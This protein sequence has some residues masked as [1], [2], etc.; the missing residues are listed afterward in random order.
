MVSQVFTNAISSL[1]E[2]DRQLSQIQQLLPLLRRGIGVHHGGLLPIMK[3]TIEVLFQEGLLK[4]LFATETFSI[5]LNMP[6]KTV[7]FTS[8]RKFDGKSMRWVSSGEYIQMSGRA[9]RR[10]LDERGVVIMMIDEKMEPAVA[11]D[12]VKGESDRMNSAFHLSYNMILNLLRVEGVSPEYMLE[13]CFFTFQNDANIPQYEKEMTQLEE[14]RDN[15]VVEREEEIAG[16]YEIRKQIDTYTQDVRDVM[17]HPTYALP[18]LQPG[19]LARIKYDN[20]DFGWGV[21]VTYSKASSKGKKDP[22]AEPEYIMDVLLYCSNDSSASK[23]AT[24]HTVGIKPAPS[25]NEGQ[26]MI[27]PVSLKA[28]ECMSHIRLNLP[29]NLR[30]KDSLKA[31]YKSI[32]EVKKRFPDNIPLLDPIKNMGIKDPAFQKLVSKIVVLE[33]T[34]L[35]HPL[36]QSEDLPSLY[37]KYTSK[38]E[39]IDKIKALKRRITDAQSI[40]QLEELKNRKRVMR[41]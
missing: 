9:G 19:R 35:A 36:A 16:Y 34:L 25:D 8:V 15:I 22:D 40:V 5:G 37:D 3:E 20:M 30:S 23:D 27:I 6:A 29:K 26:L 32:V 28:I 1:S 18:F 17:N 21:V 33:K 2:D 38:M 4:V 24:G 10:G 39:V 31:I 14:D 13:K 7:V 12:M 41:R 11:K